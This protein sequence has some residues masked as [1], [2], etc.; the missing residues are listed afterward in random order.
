MSRIEIPVYTEMVQIFFGEA[1]EALSCLESL[2]LNPPF[3]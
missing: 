2:R 3:F 1:L